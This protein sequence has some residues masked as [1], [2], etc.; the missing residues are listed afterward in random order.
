MICNCV[1]TAWCSSRDFSFTEEN[2]ANALAISAEQIKINTM[3]D[4]YDIVRGSVER[5]EGKVT[6]EDGRR[7]QHQR[8]LY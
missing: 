4:L 8:G 1:R 5:V 6:G 2:P 3:G 7:T